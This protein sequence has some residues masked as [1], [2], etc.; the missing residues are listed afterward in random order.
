[1]QISKKGL[2]LIKQF[3]GLKLMAYWCPAGV[4]TYAVAHRLPLLMRSIVELLTPATIDKAFAETPSRSSSRITLTCFTVSFAPGWFSPR[5]ST[6]PVDQACF[7]LSSLVHHSRF[8][9][10]L[11]NL[12]PLM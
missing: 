9:G 7:T 4:P 10:R 6:R 5:K 3:E 12:S 8:S 2:D 1:M 11:S